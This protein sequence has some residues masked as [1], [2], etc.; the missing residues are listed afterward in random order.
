VLQV[1]GHRALVEAT[2]V[3][4]RTHQIR[5]HLAASGTPVLGDVLYGSK[6]IGEASQL[7][8]RSVFVGYHD[9]FQKRQVSIRAP[10]DEF[11]RQFGY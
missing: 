2:P 5:I 3:T 11:R 10:V 8:L 7:A 1:K 9:P 4:G 6:M